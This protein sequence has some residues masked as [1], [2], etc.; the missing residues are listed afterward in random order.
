MNILFLDSVDKDTFGGYQ[1]WISLVSK[2]LCEKGHTV[3][4]AG[5][6]GSEYLRR[7][8]EVN[9][10]IKKF[11]LDI[12]GDFNPFTITK[13]KRFLG[14][15]EIDLVVC[16]FNK[17]VRL[18]G[19]AAKLN[20]KTKVLWRLGLDITK[21][22]FVH[23]FLTP[24]LVDA[25][26]VPS[27]GLKK[28]IVRFNYLD[29]N[30]IRVI[31]HG[32]PDNGSARIEADA[33]VKLRE[34]Y[35]LDKDSIVAVTSGRLVTQKGHVYLV[36]AAEEIIKRHP[37]VRFLL[38]GN[39]PLE[40]SL[41]NKME[42]LGVDKYF[43]FAGMLD[44]LDLEY[45][46]ADIM[47]HPSIDEPFGFSILEG[48]RAGLPVVATR[49][50]GIPEVV[51]EGETAILINA[52]VAYEISDATNKLLDSPKLMAKM[53]EAGRARWRNELNLDI[54]LNRWEK[55]MQEIVDGKIR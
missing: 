47:I 27:E 38:L 14:R 28:Q 2:G 44:N 19:I 6:P 49:V 29:P 31:P 12:S 13:I 30:K 23:R 5:R 50:G 36:E 43:V 32:I 46:G 45:A 18:G 11:P 17:D 20:G 39:G 15:E 48:M 52:R 41:R 4:A 37:R 10:R 24:R 35:G 8:G 16:D 22:R 1:N 25:I 26:G 7:V 33:D 40:D 3:F 55:Y 54:M 51:R 34:K 9:K 53:G 21:N 42:T